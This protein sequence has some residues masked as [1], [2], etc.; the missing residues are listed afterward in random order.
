M[1]K[2]LSISGVVNLSS[3]MGVWCAESSRGRYK[4]RDTVSKWWGV[5]G[6]P[7]GHIVCSMIA[8]CGGNLNRLPNAAAG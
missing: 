7:V 8:R 5:C 3:M 1:S 2:V 4:Y 6:Y